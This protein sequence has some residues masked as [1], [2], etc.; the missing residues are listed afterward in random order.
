MNLKI[1]K[2]LDDADQVLLFNYASLHERET[3]SKTSQ[4]KEQISNLDNS[5]YYINSDF[6]SA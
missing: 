3:H 5:N 2:I 4:I 6:N 1:D